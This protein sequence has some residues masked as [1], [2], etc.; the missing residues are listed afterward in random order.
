MFVQGC[1]REAASTSCAHSGT[2]A[3]AQPPSAGAVAGQSVRC[4][5]PDTL[6]SLKAGVTRVD[7][8]AFCHGYC[9]HPRTAVLYSRPREHLGS[10][11]LWPCVTMTPPLVV[12]STT[13]RLRKVTDGEIGYAICQ[14]GNP[15]HP[16]SARMPFLTCMEHPPPPNHHHHHHQM[17]VLPCHPPQP[18]STC[19]LA[20]H[21]MNEARSTNAGVCA[22]PHM[23][24]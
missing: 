21:R 20:F 16:P 10:G 7:Q 22:R 15:A 12:V 24:G 2:L 3:L 23:R 17:Q 11:T 5:V 14:T 4:H 13:H 1:T 6:W 9:L 8:A 18:P 19:G